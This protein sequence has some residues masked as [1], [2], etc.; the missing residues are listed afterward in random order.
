MFA[1]PLVPQKHLDEEIVRAICQE[2]KIHN[3]DVH[4][5]KEHATVDDLIDVIEGNRVYIPCLY[6]L[7]K[8]DSITVEELEL[9]DKV[10]HYVPISAK[11]EWNFDELLETV[12]DY[13]KMI[14]L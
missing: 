5:R 1:A 13:C 9:L 6:V 4:V 3:V 14:R 2:Y 12:W 11:D 10:P 8:V 7:N